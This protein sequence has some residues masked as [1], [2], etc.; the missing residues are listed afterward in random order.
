MK[1]TASI[2]VKLTTVSCS[3]NWVR[4]SR[5]MKGRYLLPCTHRLVCLE[6][7]TAAPYSPLGVQ[8]KLHQSPPATHTAVQSS[9][10]SPALRLTTRSH[11]SGSTYQLT[12]AIRSNGPP[13]RTAAIGHGDTVARSCS[14]FVQVWPGRC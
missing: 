1:S 2:H 7:C 6:Q 8:Q 13:K 11:K 9:T 3:S 4:W 12:V 5:L 10:V 14:H